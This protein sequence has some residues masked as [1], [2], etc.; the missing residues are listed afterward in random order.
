MNKLT[1]YEKAGRVFR[2]LGWIQIGVLALI[3]ILLLAEGKL[4]PASSV[5][6]FPAVL[7]QALLL[8]K[9]GKAIKEQK[10]RS[11]TCGIT[12]RIVMLF[13]LPIGSS[14]APYILW[15]LIEGRDQ[16]PA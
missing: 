12:M 9:F 3:P 13:A 7:H 6:L 8:P 11:P 10:E 15:R 5:L 14:T 2:L 16:K 4:L 1:A